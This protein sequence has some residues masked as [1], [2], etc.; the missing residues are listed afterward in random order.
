MLAYD[1]MRTAFVASALVAILS[2]V[3]GWFVVLRGQSFAG[4]ALSHIGFAGAAAA[5]WLSAPPLAGLIAGTL[6]GAAWIGLL[7]ERGEQRDV[8]IGVVLSASL[9]LG[10]LFLHLA[11]GS[12]SGV[13]ALLFGN[14]L[15]VSHATLLVLAVLAVV[16]LGALGVVARPLLFASL[17]PDNAV[18]RGV[19]VARLGTVF[20]VIVGLVTAACAQVTGVLLVFTLMICP[21]ATVLALGLPPLAGAL[22]AAAIAVACAWGGLALAWVSNAPVSFWISA[23]SAVVYGLGVAARR[24]SSVSRTAASRS[25]P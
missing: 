16:C 9:G 2:G 7:G 12:A 21:A 18:A 8:A 1:F 15:G 4:H 24:L 23:L 6:A 10:L 17:M 13:T 19:P 5:L 22:T 14:V 3:T 25:G 20:L 11:S